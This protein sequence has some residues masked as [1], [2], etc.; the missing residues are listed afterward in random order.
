MRNLATMP[1]AHRKDFI[2]HIHEACFDAAVA[3]AC[4]LYKIDRLNIRHNKTEV[5]KAMLADLCDKKEGQNGIAL[6]SKIDFA[7]KLALACSK[8]KM[9]ACDN[10]VDALMSFS[11]FPMM[12]KGSV[13]NHRDQN[14]ILQL[15][16][17]I[18][19]DEEQAVK[20]LCN[21]DA[22][23]IIEDMNNIVTRLNDFI[24]E[25]AKTARRTKPK[26]IPSRVSMQKEPL[27][28]IEDYTQR[29]PLCEIEDYVQREPL[30]EMEDYA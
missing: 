1:F 9:R 23:I 16:T 7:D 24:T 28:E 14:W 22:P 8:R 5:L 10:T 11:K 30:C 4:A 12:E 27:C 25:K 18:L 29:E 17:I 2:I 20:L 13:Q 15:R 19:S 6:V 26:T 3:R 21:R